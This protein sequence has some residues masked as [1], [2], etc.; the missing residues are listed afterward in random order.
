LT[1][2]TGEGG[3][4]RALA[5]F[6]AQ[7]PGFLGGDEAR[8]GVHFARAVELDPGFL[9]NH[10]D[11]AEFWSRPRKEWDS[12]CGLLAAALSLGDDPQVADRWPLY[13]RLA[14]VRARALLGERPC[15]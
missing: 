15:P 11:W 10:V 5:N 13:N 6:L 7:T 14:L 9:Q 1:K 3:P 8:A 4:H 2:G 12:F